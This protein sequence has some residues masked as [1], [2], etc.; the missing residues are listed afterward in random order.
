MARKSRII[1]KANKRPQE[2]SLP[3]KSEYGRIG[4]WWINGYGEF[5]YKG[6]LFRHYCLEKLR[7]IGASPTGNAGKGAFNAIAMKVK[8]RWL[9]ILLSDDEYYRKGWTSKRMAKV[10]LN[11]VVKQ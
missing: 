8:N 2:I 7:N 5:T 1:V 3:T 11:K 10:V 4:I 9:G 6:V